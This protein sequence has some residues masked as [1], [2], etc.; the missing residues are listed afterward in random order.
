MSISLQH[1]QPWRTSE[2]YSS[3]FTSQHKHGGGMRTGSTLHDSRYALCL[4]PPSLQL[5]A[6]SELSAHQAN[7]WSHTPGTHVHPRPGHRSQHAARAH[8]TH[9]HTHGEGRPNTAK[10]QHSAPTHVV[11]E[12]H[13]NTNTQA[14]THTR[15][16]TLVSPSAMTGV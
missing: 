1:A 10:A 4:Q 11:L 14:H 2:R 8:A 13:T 3:C 15:M 5:H 9:T 6:T 7:R 12:E 16:H